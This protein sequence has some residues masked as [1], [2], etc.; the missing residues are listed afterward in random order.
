MY[1]YAQESI[2]CTNNSVYLHYFE[3]E[4]KISNKKMY[5]DMSKNPIILRYFFMFSCK[6]KQITK[7][8]VNFFQIMV[9][10]YLHIWVGVQFKTNSTIICLLKTKFQIYCIFCTHYISSIC[11]IIKTHWI[12]NCQR[13]WFFSPS[14]QYV[15]LSTVALLH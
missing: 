1:Q 11:N 9:C 8:D 12:I 10:L 7:Y 5:V 14:K 2:F 15:Y 13:K 4:V 3:R 6:C